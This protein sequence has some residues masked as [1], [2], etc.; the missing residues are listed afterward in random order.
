[1]SWLSRNFDWLGDLF[2]NFKAKSVM[3]SRE[4]GGSLFVI[5]DLHE[6]QYLD[7]QI[8]WSTITA[9]GRHSLSDFDYYNRT[10]GS[11]WFLSSVVKPISKSTTPG[12]TGSLICTWLL[13]HN[14]I[15]IQKNTVRARSIMLSEN[16]SQEC[17]S[18]KVDQSW[19]RRQCIIYWLCLWTHSYCN[20]VYYYTIQ[21]YA[22]PNL[23]SLQALSS[24]SAFWVICTQLVNWKIS[25]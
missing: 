23:Q 11:P 16:L 15:A 14:Q 10:W 20:C 17:L 6:C 21:S 24:I 5:K 19:K 22:S 4:L 9:T 1:M 7:F 18:G 25:S 8:L 3:H 2:F 13:N 12:S